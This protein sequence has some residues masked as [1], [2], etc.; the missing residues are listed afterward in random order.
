[1]KK[2]KHEDISWCKKCGCPTCDICGYEWIPRVED[3]M[4]KCH[5]DE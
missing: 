1:M 4:C 5:E 3:C 2:C